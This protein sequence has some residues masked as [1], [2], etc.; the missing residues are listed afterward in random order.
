MNLKKLIALWAFPKLSHAGS[1]SVEVPIE[2][3]SDLKG[4]AILG[5]LLLVGVILIKLGKKKD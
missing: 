3:S 1:C 2:N 5:G 4:Y